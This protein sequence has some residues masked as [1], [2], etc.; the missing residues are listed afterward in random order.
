MDLGICL[1]SFSNNEVIQNY[2]LRSDEEYKDFMILSN[3][4]TCKYCG[5]K[6]AGPNLIINTHK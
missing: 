2:C 5:M 6:M 3:S 4:A 1:I